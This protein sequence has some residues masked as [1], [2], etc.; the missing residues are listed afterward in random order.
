MPAYSTYI[1]VLISFRF[2]ELCGRAYL[3]LR[4]HANLLITLF[5]MMLPTG[6]PELQS[7]DDIGYLRKTLAVEKTEEKALEYFQNQLFEAYGGA[8]T[9]KLDW[10]FHSVKHM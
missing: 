6:I 1:S 5:I 2:Q 7:V 3:A 4:R 9:T 10:F 8:W